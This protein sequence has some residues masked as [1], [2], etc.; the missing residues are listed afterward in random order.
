MELQPKEIG[1][2][3]R[4][5]GS[6]S[7]AASLYLNNHDNYIARSRACKSLGVFCIEAIKLE[8]GVKLQMVES[9]YSLSQVLFVR[10]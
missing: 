3:S 4:Q 1:L 7:I 9:Y 2:W 10:S 6:M 5:M 8:P